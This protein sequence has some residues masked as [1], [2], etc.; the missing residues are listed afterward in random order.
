MN[1]KLQTLLATL[2]VTGMLLAAC[3]TTCRS[4]TSACHAGCCTTDRATHGRSV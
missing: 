4:H 1:R 2:V 3:G